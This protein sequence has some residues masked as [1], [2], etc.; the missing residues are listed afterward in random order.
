MT[1]PPPPAHHPADATSTAPA[2]APA[3]PGVS[4][5]MPILNE[6]RHLEA[7][8]RQVLDQDW[9]GRLEVVLALGPSTDG[10][11]DV[12]R[13]LAAADP[14]VVLVANPTGRTPDALNAAVAGSAGAVVVRVDGHAEIPRHYVS[15]AVAV[16]DETGA[17]NVGGTM[18]ARGTTPFE[19]AVACA[20]RSRLGVGG[21]RFHTGG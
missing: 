4:V 6:E 18:D 12:A 8:V 3:L 9:P 5:V 2:P 1:T 13:R 20:M 14:R 10:T 16:L 15:T 21:G 17:D 19:R 11:D 7:A